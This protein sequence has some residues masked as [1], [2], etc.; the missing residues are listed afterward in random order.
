LV[1]VLSGQI[2]AGY[3][4]GTATPPHVE[5]PQELLSRLTPEQKQQFDAAARAFG[6]QRYAEALKG[7]QELLKQVPG[8]AVLSK[9]EAEA[10]L[11]VGDL[12]FAMRAIQ[13]V[14]EATQDDWQAAALLARVAAEKRDAKMRDAAMA[15]M[16][17]L[18]RRGLTP[19]NMNRYILERIKADV[20]TVL[21]WASLEPWGP[22]RVYYLG[23]VFNAE[24]KIYLRTTVES[25]DGDQPEFARE[26]PKEAAA[27]VRGFRLMRIR[28]QA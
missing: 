1:F 26:H 16:L 12:Q 2:L 14:A 6:G 11:N 3:Q 22:Y 10:A 17:D 13:P 20:N 24:G 18:H 27:G 25:N 21:I 28:K 9:F 23:Q 5:S 8:D 15:H 4:A 7:F 19:P